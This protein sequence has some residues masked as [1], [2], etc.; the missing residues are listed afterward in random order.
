MNGTSTSQMLDYIR[1]DGYDIVPDK[2]VDDSKCENRLECF[3]NERDLLVR[4]MNLLTLG[5]KLH[6]LMGYN[7]L[8]YDIKYLLM[9]CQFYNIFIDKFIWREGYNFGCEQIHLDL[10]R[11]IVMQYRFK[12]YTLNEVSKNIMKDSKTGV[13]AVALRFT[14]YRMLKHQKFFVHE[15]SSEKYPSIRDTLHYNNADTLL[16]SKLETRTDSIDFIIQHAKKCQVP[17]SNMNTNYNKMQYKLWN[18]CLTVGLN[19]KLFLGTFKSP[20]A[21]IIYPVASSYSP[22]DSIDIRINLTDKLLNNDKSVATT[23][24]MLSSSSSSLYQHSDIDK[25]AVSGRSKLLSWRI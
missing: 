1:K 23:T 14:F 10:F 8:N 11:I 17:L 20:V 21:S 24:A 6:F 2:K 25:K 15:E 3:T 18:V 19:L 4:T 12:S 5:D 22:F 7:S 9:R 16:V 13:S